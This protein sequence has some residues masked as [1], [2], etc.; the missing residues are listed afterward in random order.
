MF[1]TLITNEEMP[2]SKDMWNFYSISPDNR[3]LNYD[4]YFVEG[5][6]MF[7]SKIEINSNNSKL[8]SLDMAIE[9]LSRLPLIKSD[10][11]I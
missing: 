2:F 4:K 7:D 11:N 10:L 1:E 9:I 6:V 5:N 3:D 8:L